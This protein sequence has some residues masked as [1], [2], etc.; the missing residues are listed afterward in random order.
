M[1]CNTRGTTFPRVVCDKPSLRVT[2]FS[3]SATVAAVCWRGVVCENGVLSSIGLLKESAWI[4]AGSVLLGHTA[5]GVQFA[6]AF[7]NSLRS[8]S[9]RSCRVQT[10]L[11]GKTVSFQWFERR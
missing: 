10:A 7:F 9:S 8:L 1:S 5:A 2:I 11:R 4:A 3:E 6:C